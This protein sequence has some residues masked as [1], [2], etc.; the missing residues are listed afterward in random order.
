M[1]QSAPPRQ[2]TNRSGSRITLLISVFKPWPNE[3][4]SLVN[5]AISSDEPWSEKL[6]RSRSIVRRKKQVADVE[7]GQLHDVGDEHFLEEQEKPLNATPSITSAISS[8]RLLKLSP[9]DSD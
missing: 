2:L 6:A 7:E 8:S 4:M 5:R 1:N 9:G 3:S